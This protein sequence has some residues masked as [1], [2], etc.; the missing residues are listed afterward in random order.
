[1]VVAQRVE[2]LGEGGRHLGDALGLLGRQLVEILVD[3]IHRLDAVLDAV[4]PGHELGREREV[5]VARRVGSTELDALRLRVRAGQRDADRCRSVARRVDEVDRR[6]EALDEAVVAVDRRVRECEHRR[7]V[8]Q[9]SADVPA[10][11]VGQLPVALL[12]VEQRLAVEPQRL[13]RVHA[14]SVVAEDRLRHER[15]GLAPLIG[16]VLDDVLELQHIVGGVHHGVEAV[17]DLGLARSADLMVRALQLEA[18]VDQSQR[19]VVAQVGLLIDGSDG[20]VTALHGRLVR[21]VAADLLAARVPRGLF[22][23]DRDEA[24]PARDLVAHVVEDIELGL[25]GEERCVGDARRREVLLG[26]LRDLAR[27]LRIGLT[28]AGVEDVEHHDERLVLAER[29]DVRRRD[30]GDELHV[31]LVDRGEPADRGAVEHLP[32]GEELIVDRRGGNVE[33]LLHTGEIREPDVEELH[34]LLFDVRDHFGRVFEHDSSRR[35]Y[36]VRSRGGLTRR[37]YRGAVARECLDC[38]LDV[39]GAAAGET[40]PFR[41]AGAP[42]CATTRANRVKP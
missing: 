9:Q 14:R 8:L 12:V 22:G 33:V 26:L 11:E 19:D 28:V 36:R 15:R 1:M 27:I 16:D 25:G 4:D 42:R 41:P 5:R 40:N 6:F 37:N 32:D 3:R 17:V 7:S 35:S 10:G 38:F 20:E 34:V 23:V 30:I 21:E 39:T 29:V 18:G 31:R 13:V 24:A 2:H